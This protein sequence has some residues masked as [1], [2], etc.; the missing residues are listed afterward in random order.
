LEAKPLAQANDWLEKYR[1]F[2]EGSFQRLDVL[3]DEM[4]KKDGVEK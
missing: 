4:K 2:W 1:E 3:L